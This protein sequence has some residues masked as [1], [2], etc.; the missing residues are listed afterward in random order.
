MM[1]QSEEVAHSSQNW[2]CDGP[3]VLKRFVYGL[4][5]EWAESQNV[6]ASGKNNYV[7]LRFWNVWRNGY[8]RQ[9]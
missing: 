9:W 5:C 6:A 3:D 4:N 1:C 2:L 7:L 8:G